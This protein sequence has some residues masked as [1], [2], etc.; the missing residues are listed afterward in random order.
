MTSY[1]ESTNTRGSLW[2]PGK[3]AFSDRAMAVASVRYQESRKDIA[4][5][6]SRSSPPGREQPS[7]RDSRDHDWYY[8]DGQ[9]EEEA[10]LLKIYDSEQSSTSTS[11]LH[12]VF[13]IPEVQTSTEPKN[14]IEDLHECLSRMLHLL[15]L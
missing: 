2:K 3:D 10:L 8:L 7:E 1:D 9:T 14:Y 15:M 5:A 13:E 4:G 6:T 11:C 12:T